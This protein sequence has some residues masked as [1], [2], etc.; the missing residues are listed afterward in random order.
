MLERCAARLHAN[1]HHLV[2]VGDHQLAESFAFEQLRNQ[3]R[4]VSASLMSSQIQ[5]NSVLFNMTQ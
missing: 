4:G 5:D 3:E 1:G 2:V